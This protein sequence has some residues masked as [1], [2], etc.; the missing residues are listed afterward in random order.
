[1]TASRSPVGLF[2]GTFDPV[3]F[4]HLRPA[5]E[6]LQALGLAE[7]RLVP[8]HIPPHRRLPRASPAYRLRL[9]QRSVQ[10][11]PG[12]RVDDCE[13]R[14]DGPSY[15]VETLRR[16]RASLGPEQPLCFIL[17]A[18]AFLGLTG[19]YRWHEL[20]DYAHLVVMNRP[21]SPLD[22]LPSELAA[23]LAKR[24]LS[25]QQLRLAPAG[26]IRIERVSP[27]SVSSS[28]IRRCMARGESARYLVPEPIWQS[29]AGAG[30]YGYPQ[31]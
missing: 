19:W 5:V 25:R 16:F 31:L 13:L 27:V 2:G 17:G 18:D 4:G 9:I 28:G 1:M 10:G 3:H 7:L 21:D 23:W 15:T 6:L 12:L 29:I 8:G 26:G 11:V 22:D 30:V 14:R 24:R 20:T